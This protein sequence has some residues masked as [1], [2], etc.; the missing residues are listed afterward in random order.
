M[1]ALL[2]LFSLLLIYSK[3]ASAQV[4]VENHVDFTVSPTLIEDGNIQIAYGWLGPSDFRKTKLLI[5]D[6]YKINELHPNNNHMV[7]SKMAF[8]SKKS[9]DRFSHANLNKA[10]FIALMLDSVALKNKE[11]DLWQVTNKVVAYRIPFRVTFDFRF[12]EVSELAF[13]S[14][15]TEYFKDEASGFTG[16]G[17]ERFL[18]LDMTNF[19]QLLYRNY[20]VVYLKELSATETLVVA[21]VVAGFDLNN[22]NSYFQYPPFSTTKATVMS[23]LKE[24]ILRMIKTIR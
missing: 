24:Q 14:S 3:M 6:V 9:Y 21:T 16:T 13:K 12:K 11:F 17:R 5:A 1:K 20:A 15:L 23:N 22:A 4:S 7:V 19:T 18:T 10:D 2:L 8:I